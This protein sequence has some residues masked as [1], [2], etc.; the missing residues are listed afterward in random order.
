M[1]EEVKVVVI[2]LVLKK[3]SFNSTKNEGG[4]FGCQ[5]GSQQNAER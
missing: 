5:K 1:E 3:E 2:V 4:R